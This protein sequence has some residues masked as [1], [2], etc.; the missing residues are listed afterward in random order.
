MNGLSVDGELDSVLI[1]WQLPAP[2]DAAQLLCGID[3]R[4][5]SDDEIMNVLFCH[6]S[7]VLDEAVSIHPGNLNRLTILA[8]ARWDECHRVVGY[9]WRQ[10]AS[11]LGLGEGGRVG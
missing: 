5:L 1:I 10:P 11:C 7:T 2:Y 4:N 6:L 8:F 3:R 9:G